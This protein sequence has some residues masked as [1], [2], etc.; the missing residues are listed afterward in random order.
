MNYFYQKFQRFT[1]EKI[2]FQ[3]QIG[4]KKADQIVDYIEIMFYNNTR[5]AGDR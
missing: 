2:T 4:F 3:S 5:Q 1:V